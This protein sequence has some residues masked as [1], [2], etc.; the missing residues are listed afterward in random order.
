MAIFMK[1][2]ENHIKSDFVKIQEF[3]RVFIFVIFTQKWQFRFE[4]ENFEIS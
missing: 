2:L 1:N 3:A 4:I